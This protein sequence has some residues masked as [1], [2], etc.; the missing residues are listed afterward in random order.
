[1]PR[2]QILRAEVVEG[3]VRRR[4]REALDQ[5]EDERLLVA[6]AAVKTVTRS[7]GRDLILRRSKIRTVAIFHLFL[8]KITSVCHVR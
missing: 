7:G 2:N 6:R 5:L 8:R 3:R 1:M 4:S